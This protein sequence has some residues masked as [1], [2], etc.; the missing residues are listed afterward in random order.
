MRASKMTRREALGTAGAALAGI[1]WSVTVPMWAAPG[2]G[3]R[4]ASVEA[5]TWLLETGRA[6]LSPE[7]YDWVARAM[8]TP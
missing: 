4:P 7:L 8:Q 5:E 6:E 1:T 2:D 3:A